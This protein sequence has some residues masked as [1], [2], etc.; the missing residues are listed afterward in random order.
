MSAGCNGAGRQ[1]T[2]GAAWRCGLAWLVLTLGF[3]LALGLAGGQFWTQRC[4]ACAVSA[5]R[6]GPWLLAR[7]TVVSRVAHLQP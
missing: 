6:L 7:V 4:Q 1:E 5:G 3:E 2:A